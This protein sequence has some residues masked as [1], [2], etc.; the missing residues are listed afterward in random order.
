MTQ[1]DVLCYELHDDFDQ[2]MEYRE[3]VAQ[4]PSGQFRVLDHNP[5]DLGFY[6]S[7]VRQEGSYAWWFILFVILVALSRQKG[8]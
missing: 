5:L 6:L 7:D 1:E 3:C 2:M 8:L 4:S